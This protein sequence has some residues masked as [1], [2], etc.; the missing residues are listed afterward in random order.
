MRKTYLLKINRSNVYLAY[1]LQTLDSLIKARRRDF[2]TKLLQKNTS[3][4][5]FISIKTLRS[6]ANQ[7]RVLEGLIV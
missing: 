4:R 5:L 6:I 3:K 2:V 1:I 7:E